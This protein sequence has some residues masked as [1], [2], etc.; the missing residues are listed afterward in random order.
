LTAS[1]GLLTAYVPRVLRDWTEA[2]PAALCRA[3]PGSLLFA[4]ISGFTRLSERLARQGRVGAE[5]LSE[6]I[7][8]SFAALLQVAHAGGGTV[9]KFGGDALL[10]LFADEGHATRACR[11]AV[12]MRRT[13]RQLGSLRTLSGPVR[14]RMSVGVHSGIIHFFLVGDS[15]RELVVA[16]PCASETVRLEAAAAAGEI[17]VSHATAAAL[18]TSVLG[19]AKG[20]GRLLR[21]EPP[22]DAAVRSDEPDLDDAA[23][24]SYIPAAVRERL[25]ADLHEPE[26]RRVTVAFI[27][28]K[29][30]DTLIDTH[31]AER[32][33]CQLQELVSG[34]QRAV[35]RHGVSF[36]ST[37]IDEDG[38]K[39][40]LAAGAPETTGNDEE[41]MLLALREIADGEYATPVQI[42][43]N[44]DRVFAG[45]IGPPERRVYTV[46][47][48]GVNLAARLMAKARPCQIL[49]TAGVLDASRTAFDSAALEPFPV[50]GKRHPVQA[51][52]VG[53]VRGSK[54]RGADEL[55]LIGRAQELETFEAALASARAGAGRLLDVTGEPGIGK[56]RLV[57]AFVQRA[58]GLEQLTVA[59]ELY[60]SS[61]PY[62]AF[63][64][65]LRA[66]LEVPAEASNDDVARRLCEVV[67]RAEPALLPWTPL[68]ANLLDVDLPPTEATAQLDERFRRP[69]LHDVASQLLRKLL[70]GPTL[71]AF[72]G[73][74]WMDE[75]SADLLQHLVRQIETLPWLVCV[76]RRDT[77]TGFAAEDGPGVILLPLAPLEA[78][79]SALLAD[80]ATGDA[81]LPQHQMAVL[82]QRSGGNPLF[83]RELVAAAHAAGGIDELP[84]TIET[85]VTARI[86]RL[87]PR[88][89]NVLRYVAVLGQSFRRELAAAV[90]PDGAAAADDA[91]WRRL[92]DFLTVENGTIRFRH[93]LI[94]DAAYEGLRYRL[95]RELHAKVG[96][97]LAEDAG[98]GADD[99]AEL[100]S[101][102]FF[103]AQR[104]AAAWRYSLVAAESAVGIYANA[105]AARFYERALESARRVD[106]LLSFEVARVQELLGDVHDR[107]GA[108]REAAVAY[109]TARRLLPADRVGEARLMLKQ[110]QQQ[111]WLSRY[112]NALRWIRRGLGAL[113]DLATPEAAKQRAQLMVWYARFCEEEG[114]HALAITWCHRAIDEA[115]A[116]DEREALAHAYKILDWAYAYLGELDNAV[117]SAEALR[118]YEDLDNLAGQGAVL[119]NMASLANERG[120]WA[121]ALGLLQ[122]SLGICERIGD[123][124]GAAIAKYNMGVLL[125]DQGRWTEAERLI[126]EVLRMAKAAGHRALLAAAKRDLGKV[127]ARLGR[128]D[129]AGRLLEAALAEFEDVGARLEVVDTLGGI[130][131]YHLLLSETEAALRV[132]E[133]ALEQSRDLV[134]VKTPLLHRL[135]GYALLQAGDLAGAARALEESLR[136]AR[137]GHADYEI[138][139]TLR[140]LVALAGAQGE[141]PPHELES[142]SKE[143]LDRL[144]V[145]EFPTVPLA[146]GAIPAAPGALISS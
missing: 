105:D 87:P 59:C 100:L 84:D 21:R 46:M 125:Y 113:K 134:G 16:G 64:R 108:F 96:N 130:A 126:G 52:R 56:S 22:V 34:V 101:F 27:K 140:A 135:R 9:I 31:G 45:D 76:T 5:E 123:E 55:P 124:V 112:P 38:G 24:L 75:A 137:L 88:D 50:K 89:R 10:L 143:I 47:G 49:A 3:I 120:R 1:P 14:L 39:I 15:H 51:W 146:G 109:R 110:A 53:S 13:L 92:G 28:F 8:A 26:H 68:L 65:V 144:G 138:A 44:N 66:L 67:E 7:G 129:D 11:A 142:E 99:E 106:D 90:L 25:C 19:P 35:D 121:E 131:D 74:Q 30:T 70:P 43:V 133:Q 95:R 97:L 63:R 23:L 114:R 37:D 54:A 139:L 12:G 127:A 77:G 2:A 91:V 119:N 6:A 82:V 145:V 116:A 136:S 98:A 78:A 115:R 128:L 17:L 61:T 18:P 36:L 107:M 104:Y 72:K 58:G 4:D 132:I 93:I 73:A 86:D 60:E 32:V 122:R 40:I 20:P 80:A 111:G 57:E 33:A 141:A 103:H 81:P 79:A 94:R 85:L 102:H 83:L 69:R 117:Y 41:R 71:L 62:F 29:G 42:G 48:D 118:I